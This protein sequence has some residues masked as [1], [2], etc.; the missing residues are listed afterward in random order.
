MEMFTSNKEKRPKATP[1][2][3]FIRKASSGE[4]KKVFAEVLQKANEDQQ[5]VI[6]KAS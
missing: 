5:A 3:D 1:F 4:K 2:S 6:A